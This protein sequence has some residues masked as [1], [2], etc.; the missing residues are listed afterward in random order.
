MNTSVVLLCRVPLPATIFGLRVTLEKVKD[1][2]NKP[3]SRN[4]KL[5]QRLLAQP[6]DFTWDELV[7]VLSFLGYS[8]SKTGKTGGSRRKFA[9][10][11]NR[12]I[13]LHKPHP[14]NILKAYQLKQIIEALTERKQLKN[15]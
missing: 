2:D 10:A 11:E 7:T 9:D 6:K 5:L 14:G 13:S 3:M 12:I 8:E 15:E 4:E 1:E